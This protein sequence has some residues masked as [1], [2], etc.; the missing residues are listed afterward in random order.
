MSVDLVKELR[1]LLNGVTL[2]PW[3]RYEFDGIERTL[4]RTDADK[5]VVEIP[6][7]RGTGC[8][9]HRD[10]AYI[11]KCSPENIAALLDH[12]EAIRA[13]NERLKGALE[14]YA[15]EE[16]YR[17]RPIDEQRKLLDGGDPTIRISG[18][19]SAPP[20]TALSD[21]QMDRH[22]RRARAVLSGGQP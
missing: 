17:N 7:S 14:F 22:G 6:W 18:V 13:E 19:A 1:A 5:T 3:R 10:A 12:I 11:A 4:V 15:S 8:S 9:A 2:G 21:I 16:S 20:G